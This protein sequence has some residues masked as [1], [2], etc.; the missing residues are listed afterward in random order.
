MRTL[1]RYIIRQFLTNFVILLVVLMGLFLVVDLIV[2]LDEFLQAGQSK[3]E[4]NGGPAAWWT[5]VTVADF[6]GPLLCLIY[7]FFSGLIVVGAMAFTVNLL[8]RHRELTAMLAG[9]LSLYR[10]AL[11]IVAVGAMLSLVTLPIQEFVLPEVASELMR[12]KSDLKSEGLK[13]RPMQYI[14]DDAENLWS[15]RAFDVERGRLREVQ[16]LERDEDGLLERKILATEAIWDADAQAWR[17]TQGVALEP[18]GEQSIEG[19]LVEVESVPSQM[20]PTVL[21]ARRASLLRSV[22]PIRELQSLANNPTI[23]PDL[24]LLYTRTVQG[25]FSLMVLN[26]L[27]LVMALPYFLRRVPGDALKSA[28]VA[29]GLCLGAW[30]GGLLTLQAS[31]QT[32]PPV[33]S[34]WL[35]VALYLP[36]AAWMLTRIKT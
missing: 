24:Q 8:Q 7:V 15:A 1:D 2:D 16:I 32:L 31:P 19:G 27:L 29:S 20:S 36:V 10:V 13:D 26:V 34:A 25:R 30:G 3:S 35:P 6:Y 33:V 23:E 5:L 11:P 14:S 28:M 9:G 22:L 4:Q 12:S 18:G 17:L 21:L